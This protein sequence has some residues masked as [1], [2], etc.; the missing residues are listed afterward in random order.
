MIRRNSVGGITRPE[1]LHGE[2]RII[3]FVRGVIARSTC[4]ALKHETGLFSLNINRSAAGKDHNL[5]KGYPV[6]LCHQYFVARINQD[7]PPR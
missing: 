6:R 4:S 5:R 7:S 1:G 2:L 3:S